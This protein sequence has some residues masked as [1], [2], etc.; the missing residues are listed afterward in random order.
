[1]K[2]RFAGMHVTY[3]LHTLSCDTISRSATDQVHS[4]P[5]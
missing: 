4:C 3:K 1:V 2:V 5:E